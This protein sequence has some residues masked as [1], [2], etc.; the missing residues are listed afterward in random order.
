MTGWMFAGLFFGWLAIIVIA[1]LPP[2]TSAPAGMRTARCARCNAE[3]NV[4]VTELFY[5]C[6]QC[7]L[8]QAAPE[9]TVG[10]G[11]RRA[12][13]ATLGESIWR[14]ARNG[15]LVGLAFGVIGAVLIFAESQDSDGAGETILNTMVP[16]VGWPL[17]LGS[18]GALVGFFVGK[19]RKLVSKRQA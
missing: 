9:R 1:L 10:G 7:G 11:S 17:I 13:A 18:V 8:R 14:G 5:D 16:F 6:W 3:Q 15:A 12:S 2:L 4:P 19:S